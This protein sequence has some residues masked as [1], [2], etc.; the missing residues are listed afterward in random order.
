MLS[1][2]ED[3][4]QGFSKKWTSWIG[5]YLIFEIS[6]NMNLFRVAAFDFLVCKSNKSP[7]PG[8]KSDVNWIVEGRR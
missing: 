6:Y 5:S 3:F 4:G 2:K 7:V 1:V 8:R